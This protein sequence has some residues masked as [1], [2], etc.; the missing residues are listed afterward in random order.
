[1]EESPFLFGDE[2]YLRITLTAASSETLD[3]LRKAGFKITKQEGTTVT[4]HVAIGK[5][6]AISELS[7][8]QWIAPR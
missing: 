7:T 4:G 1:V 6:K 8:V 2:A 5:V 3:Q